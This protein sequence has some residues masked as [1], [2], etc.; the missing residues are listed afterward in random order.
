[1]IICSV[2]PCAA[3]SVSGLSELGS[4]GMTIR[5]CFSALFDSEGCVRNEVAIDKLCNGNPTCETSH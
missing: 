3:Q 5:P 4:Q 1:M 2:F